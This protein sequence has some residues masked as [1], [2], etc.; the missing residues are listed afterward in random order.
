M[1]EVAG[2]KFLTFND[3]IYRNLCFLRSFFIRI[4]KL[5]RLR[6]FTRTLYNYYG[7][8]EIIGCEVGIREGINAKEMLKILN[9][10]KLYL[11]DPYL[12]YQDTIGFITQDRQD[13]Y[14]K[15]AM[16]RLKNYNDKIEFIFKSSENVV[17]DEGSLEFCYIDSKHTYERLKLEIE[18]FFPY[19][20]P[21][22]ILGGH[23]IDLPSVSKAVNEF[24]F[25]NGCDFDAK[26]KC[27]WFFK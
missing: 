13:W 7:S 25:K 15:R 24:C 26:K 4:T 1:F 17:L 11:I 16:N 12:P 9:I 8:R 6:D 20:K 2:R 23:D 3:F 27:W 5:H 21:G 10:E 14:K 18:K 19:V 22:G